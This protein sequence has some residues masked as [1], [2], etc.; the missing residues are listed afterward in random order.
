MTELLITRGK[1]LRLSA[2][3]EALYGV[4]DFKARS[5]ITG[6]EIHE[7]LSSQ[8]AATA[9]VR[10]SHELELRVLSLFGGALD[11]KEDF[12]VSVT[13]DEAEYIYGG[14]K[15]IKKERAA[16]ADGR[17]IDAYTIKAKSMT[18]RGI[19]DV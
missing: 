12:S 2:E 10:E 15:V 3:G 11:G 1:D 7:F 13:D 19:N 6:H 5:T 14:C 17:V 9:A 8:P 4:T 16:N 18:K